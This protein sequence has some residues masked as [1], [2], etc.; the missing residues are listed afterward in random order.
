[1]LTV[2]SSPSKGQ[3]NGLLPLSIQNADQTPRP[4]GNFARISNIPYLK[5]LLEMSLAEVY[6]EPLI[7]NRDKHKENSPAA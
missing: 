2:P 4:F 3:F 5:A 1:M 7:I 6:L